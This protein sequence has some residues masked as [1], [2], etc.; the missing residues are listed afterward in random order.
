MTTPTTERRAQLLLCLVVLALVMATGAVGFSRKLASF[1]PLGFRGEE[2]ASHWRVEAVAEPA[3]GLVAGDQILLVDGTTAGRD[4]PRLLR[5]G[6]E[7]HLVVARGEGAS[8]R[9]PTSRRRSRSTSATSSSRSSGSSPRIALFALWRPARS[10][11]FALGAASA[12]VY[13]LPRSSLSTARA[14]RSTCSKGWPGS[15]CHR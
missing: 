15:S 2:G 6:G 7:H 13:L 1:Q 12:A 11:L 14:G 4:L 10:T 3:T 5:A 9:S 8:S